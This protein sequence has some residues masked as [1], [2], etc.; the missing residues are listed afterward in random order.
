MKLYIYRDL[1]LRRHAQLRRY[2]QFQIAAVS[3]IIVVTVDIISNSSF[4]AI[5]LFVSTKLTEA[6][7]MQW[8]LVVDGPNGQSRSPPYFLLIELPDE[9]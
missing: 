6:V 4:T 2:V 5:S 3:S 9:G 8:R 7:S 1:E